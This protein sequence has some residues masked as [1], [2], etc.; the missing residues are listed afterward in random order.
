M[1]LGED[2]LT[3]GADGKYTIPAA[4]LT[5]EALTVTVEKTAQ[6]TLEINVSEYVK[7]DGTTMW[8]VTASGTVS[9]GKILAYDG[10]PMFWSE[11]YNAY[12]YLVISDKPLA[13]VKAEAETKVAEA[14]AD[15]TG[16]TY[17][18]DVNETTMVDVND[19]QL[20][21]NMYNAKYASFDEVAMVRFLKADCNGDKVLNVLDANAVIAEIM[22]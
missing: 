22:K 14:A 1:K 7:L 9:D 8:L 21:Y 6:Q 13:D 19:A 17:D 3:A 2:E 18:F 10:T 12:A 20:V 15:K 5:G 4:K 11:K 16:V